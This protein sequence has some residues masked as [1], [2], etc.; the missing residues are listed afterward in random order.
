MVQVHELSNVEHHGFWLLAMD[1]Y[2][3]DELVAS[4][5][6]V[7]QAPSNVA[8]KQVASNVL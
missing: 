1:R 5:P 7:A 3:S 2:R 8:A 6:L 4:V